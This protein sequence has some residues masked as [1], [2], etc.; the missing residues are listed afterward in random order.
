M[1]GCV[2]LCVDGVGAQRHFT[3]LGRT[4]LA[5]QVTIGIGDERTS[6]GQCVVAQALDV[7]QVQAVELT[8]QRDLLFRV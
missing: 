4:D 2:A 1:R 8:A 3:V 6:I 5:H 7:T